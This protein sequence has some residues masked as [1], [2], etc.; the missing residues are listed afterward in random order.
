MPSSSASL[1]VEI[2]GMNA[3]RG[4]GERNPQVHAA[5]F[6]VVHVDERVYGLFQRRH[7]NVGHLAVV[8]EKLGGG[9]EKKVK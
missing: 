8:L 7:R 4:F 5:Q 2:L 6:F 3:L 9:E 1:E